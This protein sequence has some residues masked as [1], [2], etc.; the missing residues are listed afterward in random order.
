MGLHGGETDN[1][2]EECCRGP[3]VP[4]FDR[5]PADLVRDTGAILQL[6]IA[7]VMLTQGVRA[8]L[9]QGSATDD[10]EG[11]NVETDLVPVA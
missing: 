8:A 11:V 1:L 7:V 2:M 4:L 6:V 5:E 9:R 3:D 10:I